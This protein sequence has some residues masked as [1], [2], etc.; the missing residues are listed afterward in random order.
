MTSPRQHQQSAWFEQTR[1]DWLTTQHELNI[2]WKLTKNVSASVNKSYLNK[3]NTDVAVSAK[4]DMFTECMA[5]ESTAAVKSRALG[6][7]SLK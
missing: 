5:F 1:S 7:K 2:S 3:D 6:S 4:P